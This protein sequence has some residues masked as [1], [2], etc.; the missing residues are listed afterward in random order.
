[1]ILEDLADEVENDE[2]SGLVLLRRIF[3]I[4]VENKSARGFLGLQM[5]DDGCTVK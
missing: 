3:V 2:V 1:M 5:L 4:R